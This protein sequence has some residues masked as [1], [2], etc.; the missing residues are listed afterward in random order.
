MRRVT[1]LKR[2]IAPLFASRTNV[3]AFLRIVDLSITYRVLA[4]RILVADRVSIH[5]A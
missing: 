2:A 5:L 3:F 4:L 1:R